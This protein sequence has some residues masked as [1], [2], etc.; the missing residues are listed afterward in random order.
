MGVVASV[1]R[2]VVSW[3]RSKKVEEKSLLLSD[4][5]WGTR[6]TFKQFDF[7]PMTSH[8]TSLTRLF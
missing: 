7:F 4:P 5:F 1:V 6:L 3:A 2:G 8:F